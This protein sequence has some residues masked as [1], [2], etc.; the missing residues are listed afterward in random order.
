MHVVVPATQSSSPWGKLPVR[1]PGMVVLL[2]VCGWSLACA[3]FSDESDFPEEPLKESN[4]PLL[5]V[6]PASEPE[7]E[8]VAISD[9]CE[10]G[11]E[12]AR[13][14][15]AADEMRFVILSYP[16]S[17]LDGFAGRLAD[18]YN[19]TLVA[20]CVTSERRTKFVACYNAEVRAELD[21]RHGAGTLERAF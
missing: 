18:E 6:Q 12:R 16:S 17:G 8:P 11:G 4:D 19:V 3:G 2:L 1:G 9:P 13:R 20:T 15:I 21:R 5:Y 14:D 10:S 7:P